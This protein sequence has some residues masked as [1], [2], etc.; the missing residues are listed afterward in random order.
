MHDKRHDFA[1]LESVYLPIAGAVF[2][3]VTLLVLY[4][5]IRRRRRRPDE[6]GSQRKENNPLEL[7]YAGVLVA[8]AVFLVTLTFRTEDRTDAIADR[9]GLE[10]KIAAGQ[11]SWRFSYP[12]YGIT[13]QSTPLRPA[14]LVVPTGT[15]VHFTGTS[16]DVIHSFWV[17]DRR[18]KRDLFPRNNTRFD[19]TWPKPG[20]AR[21]ECAEFCGLLHAN[22][23]FVVDALSPADFRAWVAA[24]R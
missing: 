12:A 15:I 2:A 13:Q 19:I 21:G 23:D 5:V 18:F 7:A 8:I 20:F 1:G 6:I 14:Q 24:H 22:M 9:P 10:V 11:W 3:I 16:T 4:A 17:P